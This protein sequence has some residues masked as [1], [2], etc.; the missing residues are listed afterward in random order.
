MSNKE[1]AKFVFSR[2][3][4]CEEVFITSDGRAFFEAKDAEAFAPRLKDPDIEIHK[5]DSDK[6]EKI[7]L[8]SK[9]PV[10]MGSSED[11]FGALNQDDP[12][13]EKAGDNNAAVPTV[14]ELQAMTQE[15][16]VASLE[17]VD[18]MEPLKAIADAME[19]TLEGRAS[20][21]AYRE[22]IAGAFANEDQN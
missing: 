4:Q 3:P 21:A 17:Q 22:A 12:Q 14:A 15:N 8:S 2:N 19:I 18:K 11:V 13:A 1:L 5:R 6:I 16:R 7:N 10:T 20:K 9:E